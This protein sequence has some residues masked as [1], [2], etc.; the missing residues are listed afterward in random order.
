M[1][2]IT[3]RSGGS[4][5]GGGAGSTGTSGQDNSPNGSD[6][7]SASGSD[8]NGSGIDLNESSQRCNNS[9]KAFGGNVKTGPIKY[10]NLPD[11]HFCLDHIAIENET[12]YLK[13]SYIRVRLKMLF[14]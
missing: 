10:G 5:S 11:S 2:T 6:I 12:C 9:V 1:D 7:D 8:M 3:R 14:F 13:N 4:S